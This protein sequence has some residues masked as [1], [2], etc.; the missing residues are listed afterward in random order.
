MFNNRGLILSSNLPI[1]GSKLKVVLEND[2]LYFATQNGFIIIVTGVHAH[3]DGRIVREVAMKRSDGSD[4]MHNGKV[5]YEEDKRTVK[6]L[7]ASKAAEV[8]SLNLRIEVIDAW[9]VAGDDSTG[10]VDI[11][12]LSEEVKKLDPTFLVLGWCWSHQAEDPLVQ[13][14]VGASLILQ[15]D[16]VSILG[17]R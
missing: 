8:A 15:E 6:E 4:Y 14:G 7:L 1:T 9:Q 2:W 16:R 13:H 12:K 3:E 10:T 5:F 11:S 17:S